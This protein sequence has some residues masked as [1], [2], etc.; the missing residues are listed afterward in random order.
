[1]KRTL[2]LLT[3]KGIILSLV[4][5]FIVSC[6][7]FGIGGGSGIKTILL[8]RDIDQDGDNDV[9]SIF[10][11]IAGGNQDD[12][13]NSLHVDRRGKIY[14]T[15]YSYNG[16]NYDMYVIRM[17]NDGSLDTSFGTNGKVVV[18]NIAGGNRYDAGCA[19]YVDSNGKVYV[20]GES[21]NGR[22]SDMYV[23][24]INSD[25]SLDNLFG[26][27]GKVVLNNIAG[28]NGGDYGNS[29]YVDSNGKIYVTGSSSNGRDYDMYVIRI[30][31]DGSLDNLFGTNG[32]VVVNNIAGGNGWDS[33]NSIYVDSNGKVYVTGYSSNGSNEDMYVIKINSDGSLDN[34]FGANGKVVLNNIAGGNGGDYGNSLYVDRSGKIYVTGSSSNG[35]DYDMYVIRI[36]SDG[37]VDNTFGTNGKVVFNSIAE[38]NY[39]DFGKSIY[40]DSSGK[41]YVTGSSWKGSSLD[42]YVIRLNSGGSLDNTFATNG[43]VVVNNIAGRNSSDSGKSIYVDRSGKI[44]ITGYSSNRNN[45]DMYMI[46]IE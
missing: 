30:N 12:Y 45:F 34:L 6:N 46:K 26:A 11:N 28:G 38:G 29:L 20:T 18:N 21:S 39:L 43:K 10:H 8:N 35:R 17:N 15:G 44:Y 9:V 16:S 42:M 2:L 5:V 40:V 32:K 14:V 23:I 31:S 4:M 27:N 33:G 22:N 37:S 24:K 41:I 3:L 19:L 1:M 25:G 36:N 13:G 7:L